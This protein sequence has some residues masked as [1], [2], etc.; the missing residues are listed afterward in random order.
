MHPEYIHKAKDGIYNQSSLKEIPGE[1]RDVYFEYKK[2]GRRYHLNPKFK[3]NII[4]QSRNLFNDPPGCGYHIIFLRNNLL[5][6]YQHHLITKPLGKILNCLN[7]GGWLIVGSHE[8]LPNEF[9][10]LIRKP[11]TPWA[12]QK[13]VPTSSSK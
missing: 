9:S 10:S 8:K 5:T 7:P 1:M 12:Y 4:W 11:A 13:D 2:R 3:K 6:Y